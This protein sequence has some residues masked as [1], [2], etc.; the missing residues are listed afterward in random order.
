MEVFRIGKRPIVLTFA[1]LALL[2]GTVPATAY[3][4]SL[5][6]RTTGVLAPEIAAPV[7]FR[8]PL[9][10]LVPGAPDPFVTS[11]L[12]EFVAR[13]PL[14]RRAA[15]DPIVAPGN[16]TFGHSHDFFGNKTV[17]QSST[18][19]SL[20]RQPTSCVPSADASA[21]WVPTVLKAGV[22]IHPT[23][24]TIYYQVK[25]PYDP[26]KVTPFPYGLRMIA[27]DAMAMSEQPDYV[28]QWH[29]IGESQGF[30][31]IPDCGSHD[32]ELVLTFPNCWD[33]INL[34]SANHKSHVF[35]GRG[36]NCPL[37]HPVLLPELSFRVRW[38]VAGARATLSSDVM[39]G[40]TM[41][42]GTT[43][44]GDFMNVW[45]QAELAR[46]VTGCLTVARVCDVSG[47]VIR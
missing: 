37:S 6:T 38:A 1:V 42:G 40:H 39:P 20:E 26:T 33:G 24:F 12:G 18:T 8:R 46:R 7:A 22:P 45:E 23:E 31:V 32:L 16:A 17:D 27:G 15:M 3:S 47:S 13:C 36:L 41:P 5:R 11:G 30:A 29:C 21:Y 25:R 35:Y 44:H 34:D 14:V 2:G 28:V 19:A 10:A 4:R 9:T 43:A